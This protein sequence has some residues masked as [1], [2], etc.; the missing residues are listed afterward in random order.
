MADKYRYTLHEP[1]AAHIDVKE[2]RVVF[3]VYAYEIDITNTR[4]GEILLMDADYFRRTKNLQ[5]RR[6]KQ[7]EENK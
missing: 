7:A 2:G 5:E 4:L 1:I 3:H 6:A